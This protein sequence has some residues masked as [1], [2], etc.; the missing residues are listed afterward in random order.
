[1]PGASSLE[2]FERIRH[3]EAVLRPGIEAICDRHGLSGRRIDR[4]PDGSLPVY[5][6]GDSSVLKIYPPVELR[7]RDN[8]SEVLQ[9]LERRL[10]I[11]TPSVQ[12]VG[13]LDGWGYLLMTRL[14][15]ELLSRA[16]PRLSP[17]A[18]AALADSLGVA[19]A[20]LHSVRDSRLQGVHGIWE[21]FI[22]EQRRTSVERQ[23]AH[24]LGEEWLEQIP[25]YLEA[26]DLGDSSKQVLLHTEIMREHLL[27]QEQ[28]GGWVLSGLFDFEPATVGA[29]E[30]EFASVG[31]FFSAGDPTLLRR[32]LLAYGYSPGQLSSRLSERLLALALLHR[33][34]NF[35]WYLK[36]MPPPGLTRT[37]SQLA[38][39]WWGVHG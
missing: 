25:D 31:L 10:T 32:T 26:I 19:L 20:S 4:F 5:A 16:W 13:E 29:P 6:V 21:G 9:V 35:V 1:M 3:D 22:S 39:H 17:E 38:D 18:R 33:Y 27:V 7:E 11:R 2:E 30:Y 24:G 23:R 8:E 28:S 12:A 34:S 36:R 14:Q 15:G 37:L